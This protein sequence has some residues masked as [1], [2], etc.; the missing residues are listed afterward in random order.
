MSRVTQDTGRN[1]QLTST[2]LSP[3]IAT[4][5][6][7]FLFVVL[8]HVPV[9]QPHPCRNMDGLGWSPFARHYLGNHCYFL[10]LRVLRCFSSPRWPHISGD[11]PSAYRVVPFGN[12]RIKGY[13]LLN[14][15]YRSLSRPSSPPRA[16]ASTVCPCLLSLST[17][18]R[19]PTERNR[20]V[21]VNI[22]M[23]FTLYSLLCLYNMSMND[24]FS[25]RTFNDR[26][27]PILKVPLRGE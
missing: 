3:Y 9:L 10:F 13:L 20:T 23:S 14:A 18:V 2:G 15:A 17:P 4:L 27:A 21:A 1:K 16:K 22:L 19:V 7:V 25:W 8:F 26:L 12:P 6:R 11:M 5:S 24:V